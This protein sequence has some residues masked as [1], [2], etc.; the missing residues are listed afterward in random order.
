MSR[1]AVIGSPNFNNR[2]LLNGF[3]DMYLY[4][5]PELVIITYNGAPFGPVSLAIDWSL[6]NDLDLNFHTPHYT[7]KSWHCPEETLLQ[8]NI[9]IMCDAD[10]AIIFW[11]GIDEEIIPS[12]DICR[13]QE[14]T[15]VIVISNDDIPCEIY[16]GEEQ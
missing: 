14:K 15:Q 6:D 8:T 16:D 7:S 11:D 12:F 1:L 5:D 4:D 10:E 9:D 2:K 13:R 3:L